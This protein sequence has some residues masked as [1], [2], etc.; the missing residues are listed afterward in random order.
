HLV[1]TMPKNGLLHGFAGFFDSVLYGNVTLSIHPRRHTNYMFSWFPYFIPLERPI[2]VKQG[3]Q[4]LVH[5]NRRVDSK[6]VWYEWCVTEPV[7]TPIH[8]PHGRSSWI[9]LNQ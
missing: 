1:F 8:N 9:G 4:V 7:A 5:F 2:Y 3:S 6:R